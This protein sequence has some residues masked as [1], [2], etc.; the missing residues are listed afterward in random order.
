MKVVR[1]M[2]LL[3]LWLAPVN[4][5][6]MMYNL[7]TKQQHMHIHVAHTHTH[8]CAHTRHWSRRAIAYKTVSPHITPHADPSVH[9]Q[10]TM[11]FWWVTQ[12]CI[13]RRTEFIGERVSDWAHT[14]HR[15]HIWE[16]RIV[17]LEWQKHNTTTLSH[18]DSNCGLCLRS[19]ISTS[20]P[21]AVGTT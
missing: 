8:T 21:A 19:W 6:H 9:N 14:V 17:L 20:N 12:Q 3:W 10:W 7:V 15:M 1:W 2:G 5:L 11:G 18:N 13:I 4:I 16:T